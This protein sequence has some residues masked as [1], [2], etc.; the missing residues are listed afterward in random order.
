MKAADG[1]WAIRGCLTSRHKLCNK[2]PLR[3]NHCEGVDLHIDKFN[4]YLFFD[5]TSM[6]SY[7]RLDQLL[8]R[9]VF[10]VF[11]STDFAVSKCSIINKISSWSCTLTCHNFLTIMDQLSNWTLISSGGHPAVQHR[12]VWH[13][14]WL[15]IQE[16]RRPSEVKH[17]LKD[18]KTA[19]WYILVFN[20]H[21]MGGK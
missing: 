13:M 2:P 10:F 9:R 7:V 21:L 20:P 15:I 16:T 5:S 8:H 6:E 18:L 1:V 19:V 17:D 11:S 3:T 4:I 14:F 12:P